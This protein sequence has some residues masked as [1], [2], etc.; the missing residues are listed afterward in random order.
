MLNDGLG[1][2]VSAQ[3][4]HPTRALR[5]RLTSPGVKSLAIQ[6]PPFPCSRSAR[7]ASRTRTPT[8]SLPSTPAGHLH[9][10]AQVR[11][12]HRGTLVIR[13]AMLCPRAMRR[14]PLRIWAIP[15]P[16][17]RVIIPHCGSRPP[18]TPPV[19]P[20]TCA[21]PRGLRRARNAGIVTFFAI[22][23]QVRGGA[24]SRV[25]C[26]FSRQEYAVHSLDHR[27]SGN[28]TTLKVPCD[29]HCD[30]SQDYIFQPTRIYLCVTSARLAEA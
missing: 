14:R 20:R 8:E 25:L 23:V 4:G 11:W 17:R 6:R 29:R 18:S 26:N 15:A 12:A 28:T 7:C 21:H 2:D 5:L 19:L 10:L 30:N 24:G 16:V 13:Y 27:A 1:N 3:S 9:L 22:V